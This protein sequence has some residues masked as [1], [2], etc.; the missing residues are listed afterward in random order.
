[1]SLPEA[2]DAAPE[3]SVIVAVFNEE[4]SI[5]TCL[6]QI[7][8]VYPTECEILVVDG[9]SDSTGEIVLRMAREF[10]QVRYIRNENDLGKGHATQVGIRAARGTL[11]A[12]IDADMQFVPAELPRLIEPLRQGRADVVLGSRFMPGSVRHPGSTPWLRTFGN[13]VV[14]LYASILFG[15]RMTD[16][17]AGMSAWTRAAVEKTGLRSNNSSYEVE[18]PVKAL[19]AGLR[20]LDVPVTTD[21]RKTG[22]SNVRLLPDGLAILRD[23]TLFRLG[24][25]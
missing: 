7:L 6:R 18:L 12:E 21:A 1:M 4:A 17:L 2:P 10:P 8:A 22:R 25:R 16:V 5:E 24:W 9:G 3:L 15:Q 13:S 11:M 14:S 23:I 19:R 20:V